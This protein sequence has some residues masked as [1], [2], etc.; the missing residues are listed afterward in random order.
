MRSWVVALAVAGSVHVGAAVA[1]EPMA[2][3]VVDGDSLTIGGTRVRLWGIDAPES[4]QFCRDRGRLYHCGARATNHLASLIRG[5]PVECRAVSTD[6]YGRVVA[7]CV[8]GGLDLGQ[9]M[10]AA[11]WALDWREFSGGA[12]SAAQRSAQRAG[13]GLWSGEFLAPWDWRRNP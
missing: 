10:V 7:R 9:G 5:Q 8:A 13:R 12:Y 1:A 3:V 11:G 2:V 4:H 6:R